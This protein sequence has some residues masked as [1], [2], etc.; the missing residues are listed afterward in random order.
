MLYVIYRIS[1]NGYPKEK[2]SFATKTYC[3]RNFMNAFQEANVHVLLDDPNLKESTKADVMELVDK[4]EC[5]LKVYTGGSSAASWRYGL[6]YAMQLPDLKDDDYLY[7]VEDDYLH[8]EG[9]EAVLLEGLERAHYVSLYDHLDKYIPAMLG[10]NKYIDRDGA[11]ITKVT[12][13]KSSHWKLTNSTTMTF[14][15]MV[16]TI[17][18]DKP[19]WDRW[20]MGSYPHDFNIFIELREQGRT[21]ITPIPSWSTHCLLEWVAPLIDWSQV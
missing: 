19:V 5:S 11:E 4:N 18:A 3:L 8:K 14:A 10:G 1:D 15:T 7:F 17:K 9:S 20:T 21:L 13:T 16:S 6:E 2:F 12:L